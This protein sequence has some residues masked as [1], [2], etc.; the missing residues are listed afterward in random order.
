[1]LEFG[2]VKI[3]QLRDEVSWRGFDPREK[4]ESFAF[5]LIARSA[6]PTA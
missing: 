2:V 4:N 3:E 5:G 1:M 6:R